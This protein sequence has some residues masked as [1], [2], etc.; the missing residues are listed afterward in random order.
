VP[1]PPSQLAELKRR[2]DSFELDRSGG[3]TWE[4]LRAQLARRTS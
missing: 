1:V 4:Q 2:L 3:M